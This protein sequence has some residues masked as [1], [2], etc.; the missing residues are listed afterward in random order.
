MAR[1]PHL[2]MECG[3]LSD[4]RKEGNGEFL[5]AMLGS[6]RCQADRARG[7]EGEVEVEGV[8]GRGAGGVA[9]QR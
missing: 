5:V 4:N 6:K 8:M 2:L 7:Q 3:S 1:E 9:G